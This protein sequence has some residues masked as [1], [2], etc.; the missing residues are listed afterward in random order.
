MPTLIGDN[1]D[2][3][4]AIFMDDHGAASATFEGLFNFLHTKYFPRCAF[5]PGYLSGKKTHAFSDTCELLGFV[6]ND[7]GMRPSDKYREKI[8]RWPTPTNRAELDAFVWLTPF[9]RIFI[10]GRSKQVLE[11]KRAYLIQAPNDPKPK[12]P[13]DDDMEECDGDL[14]RKPKLARP[15]KPTVQ[16]KWVEKD[17]FDWTSSQQSSFDS[18]KTSIANNAMSGVDSKLQFHLATDASET[19]LGGCVFQLHGTESGTEVTSKLLPHE[20]IIMFLSYKLK[21]AE[22]RYSNSE[23]GCFAIV[24]ALAEIRWLV[25]GSKYPVMIY[26][27]HEALKA[28]FATENTE[29]GRIAT[30]LDMLGDFDYLV[31]TSSLAASTLG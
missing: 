29:K 28:I 26:T 22:T 30:W 2:A 15:K 17:T 18:V 16:R 14:A 25:I 27:D 31:F 4:F 19:G 13:H 3:S 8:L 6:G 9:L 11:M 24:K 23:R 5:A 1:E 21:D 7:A 12:R 20:R 10:P